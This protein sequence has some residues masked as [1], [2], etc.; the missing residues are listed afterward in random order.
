LGIDT[1]GTYTD[2]AVVDLSSK[3][4]VAKFKA[5]T[6]YYDLSIGLEA[7]IKGV[8]DKGGFDPAGIRLVG[9]STTLATNS[10]L[11][12]KGGSVGLIGIGWKPEAEWHLGASKSRF[13]AGGH[14]MRGRPLAP[15]DDKETEAAVDEICADVDAVVVSSFFSVV[16][17]AH[18]ES[19]RRLVRERKGLPVVA[20]HE[21]TAELGILERTVTAVLNAR[22]L[23][24]IDDFLKGVESSLQGKGVEAPIMVF[25]GD[26]TLMNLKK[27][28][29][30]PVETILSGPAASLMGGLALSKL[31]R[32]IVIDI[33]GT[34]TD[35]AYL[36]QGFPRLGKEGATV[37]QWKTR[38]RAIDIWTAGLGGDSIIDLVDGRM[39]IGPD[40]VLPLEVAC[41]EHPSL[42]GK[43]EALNELEFL[44]AF[45]RDPSRLPENERKIF[46]EIITRGPMTLKEAIETIDGVYLTAD[47]VKRLKAKTFLI[48][49]GLTPTD[50]LNVAGLYRMGKKEAAELGVEILSA[51]HGL[52]K[53][54]FVD[55]FMRAMGA[56]VAEEVLKKA[57][58]DAS[59]EVPSGKASAFLL[60]ALT[61]M[62][63]N[64]SVTL[65]SKLD[66][67]VVG[68]G[69]PAHI[70]LP[71]IDRLLGTVVN[72][73]HDHDVGNAVG[74]VCSMVSESVEVQIHK[75]DNYYFVYLPDREPI[76]VEHLEQALYAAKE[77][78]SKYVRKKVEEAGGTDISVLLEVE[79]K[80]CRT[81]VRTVRE[82]LNWVEVR[83]R[84]T[85]RPTIVDEMTKT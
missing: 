37:G 50:V 74:A 48:S 78:A 66:R 1:G 20:G 44:V 70:Y 57:V 31:D 10:L 2:A 13:I 65:S 35:I 14:D 21:L 28:R 41:A 58:L 29:E 9:L 85:G 67:P 83:A 16:N 25:R 30:R 51:R 22:L 80:K 32:C 79:M 40:R 60:D 69:A 52:S 63:K 75:R 36:D 61:G 47:Y 27:A 59:G 4:V 42:L 17:P 45:P 38:V 68:I 23:P 43:M 3:D 7:A 71:M 6:T 54:E 62:S 81:G 12:G 55:S 46:Q 18:E 64:G 34:S 49:T 15:L 24:I 53:K 33:G 8:M 5:P 11:Q 56:R 39:V 76:E 77:G 19:V 82:L 84:A 72:I 26:G 73:P